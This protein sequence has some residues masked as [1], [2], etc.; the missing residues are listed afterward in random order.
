MKIENKNSTEIYASVGLEIKKFVQSNHGTISNFCKKNNF[1]QSFLSKVIHGKKKPSEKLKLAL[2]DKGFDEQYFY[3][4]ID[5]YADSSQV[6][7]YELKKLLEKQNSLIDF[8]R[9]AIVEL[10]NDYDK[11]RI[12]T[13]ND[14]QRS[15]DQK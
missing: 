11:L 8:Y 15:I 14:R 2:L 3:N 12:L 7:I 1:S 6:L 9:R 13:K 4:Y 10:R 5:V